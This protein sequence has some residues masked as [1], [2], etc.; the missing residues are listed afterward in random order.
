MV[1]LRV[2]LLILL[3]RL[4]GDG[5]SY[6]WSNCTPSILPVLRRVVVGAKL[7]GVFKCRGPLLEARWNT[8]SELKFLSADLSAITYGHRAGFVVATFSDGLIVCSQATAFLGRRLFALSVVR[9]LYLFFGAFRGMGLILSRFV[10]VEHLSEHVSGLFPRF[11]ITCLPG[12]G[13]QQ[14]D[15]ARVCRGDRGFLAVLF[16]LLLSQMSLTTCWRARLTP[17]FRIFA[18]V[19]LWRLGLTPVFDF[20]YQHLKGLLFDLKLALEALDLI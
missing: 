15:R 13:D 5:L 4:G 18:I 2:R 11:T 8:V 12:A 16:P 6:R 3:L 1:P 14:R 17:Y 10:H 19:K 7:L 9:V 20:A